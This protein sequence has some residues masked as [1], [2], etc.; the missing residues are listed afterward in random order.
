MTELVEESEAPIW[1]RYKWRLIT[2]LGLVL[3]WLIS[4]T[5]F[6]DTLSF[7]INGMVEVAPLVIPGILGARL[8][9][10]IEYWELSYQQSTVWET[11]KRVINM[12]EG[13]LVVYGSLIGGAVGFA[14]FVRRY[15]LP[16]LAMADPLNVFALDDLK[17]M[18]TMDPS[19]R[20]M[21]APASSIRGWTSQFGKRVQV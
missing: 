16:T 13:G 14:A 18:T 12:P 15:R 3:F 2:L 6:F 20:R 9:H 4:P 11:F 21:K 17:M 5:Q 1:R 10:V 7:V 8:F 19:A